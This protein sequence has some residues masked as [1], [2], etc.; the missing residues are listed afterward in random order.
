MQKDKF[1]RNFLRGGESCPNDIRCFRCGEIP[2]TQGNPYGVT[3]FEYSRA[4]DPTRVSG[5]AL[6][7]PCT[8]TMFEWLH[9][10]MATNPTYIAAKDQA[11][12]A[13]PAFIERWNS[14]APEGHR[15]DGG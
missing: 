1:G 4:D 5:F 6:C 15:I 7:S 12:A 14:E 3:I 10:D 2:Y 8:I 9:P 13:I 11:V